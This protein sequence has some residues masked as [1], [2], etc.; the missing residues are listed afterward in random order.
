MSNAMKS[1]ES[2]WLAWL[3]RVA[4]NVQRA[5][6]Q[7]SS[8][9][10]LVAEGWLA[11]Q[12]ALTRFDETRG[13]PAEGYAF[14]F[15]RGA[16]LDALRKQRQLGAATDTLVAT[17]EETAFG[18]RATP[19]DVD[20]FLQHALSSIE[21]LQLVSLTSV[22]LRRT[23]EG[24]VVY[25]DALLALLSAVQS[26]E[27]RQRELIELLYLQK[28]RPN[29]EM[30]E[31]ATRFGIHVDSARRIHRQALEELARKLE[32]LRSGPKYWGE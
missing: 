27:P 16:M 8:V 6:A 14:P 21:L 22:A 32:E 26:L 2:E 1:S 11:L 10:D 19:G 24:S 29:Y 9:D 31:V 20:S 13:V 3:R 12:D 7:H 15:V 17:L 4:I 30:P 23:P 25:R 5:D 18:A 28:E